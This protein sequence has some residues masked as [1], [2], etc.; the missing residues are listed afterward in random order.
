MVE[1]RVGR[2]GSKENRHS[3]V[4]ER[5]APLTHRMVYRVKYVVGILQSYLW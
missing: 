4:I 3:V 2:D 1:L 5:G